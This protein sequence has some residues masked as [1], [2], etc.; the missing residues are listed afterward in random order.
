MLGGNYTLSRAYGNVEGE[1]VNGGP[2][3]ASLHHYPEYRRPEW[4]DPQGDLTIHQRHRARGWATY[5][6]R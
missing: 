5:R 4:H 3:G 6:C 1:T 2:S